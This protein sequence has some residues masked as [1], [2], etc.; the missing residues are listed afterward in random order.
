MHVR[1]AR[2]FIKDA[3]NSL[4]LR[5]VNRIAFT[6]RTKNVEMVERF[7]DM[8]NLATEGLFL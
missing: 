3:H 4:E 1:G 5:A 8:L 2:L 7:E 6:R